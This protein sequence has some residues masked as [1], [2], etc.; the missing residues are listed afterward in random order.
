MVNTEIGVKQ[1]IEE[2]GVI[3]RRMK[4]F[5]HTD[6]VQAVGKVPIDVNAMNIDLMS[7]ICK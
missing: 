3:C 7:I 5:F 6:A 2:V 4:V 1:P